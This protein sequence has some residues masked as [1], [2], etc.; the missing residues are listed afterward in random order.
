MSQTSNN[1]FLQ[2]TNTVY[3]CIVWKSNKKLTA[4]SKTE[5]NMYRSE[6]TNNSYY[7][8]QGCFVK[9]T[10]IQINIMQSG[11]IQRLTVLSSQIHPTHFSPALQ[12]MN[13]ICFIM[14]HFLLSVTF[15]QN[16][17]DNFICLIRLFL[18]E[19]CR[20]WKNICQYLIKSIIE[21]D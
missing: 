13:R 4:L 3:P 19:R 6:N 1:W 17:L 7:A 10:Q 20:P 18:C 21:K 15:V 2:L 5:L 14:N 8:L 9:T 16:L 11:I 12:W